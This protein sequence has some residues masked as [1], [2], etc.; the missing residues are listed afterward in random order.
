MIIFQS[1]AAWWWGKAQPKRQSGASW[2]TE[3]RLSALEMLVVR[4]IQVFT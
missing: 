2:P 3:A 1:L 4:D